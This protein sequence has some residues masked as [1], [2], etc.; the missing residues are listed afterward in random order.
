MG[1]EI[2]KWNEKKKKRKKRSFIE[3]WVKIVERV[4]DRE[5]KGDVSLKGEKE[6][7]D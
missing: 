5:L 6:E 3:R 2:V 1:K 7:L 4:E